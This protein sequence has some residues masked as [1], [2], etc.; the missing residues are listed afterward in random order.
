MADLTP[1][2][3]AQ[4]VSILRAAHQLLDAAPLV[5]EDAVSLQLI[6][7]ES[8]ARITHDSA[9]FQSP[10]VRALRAHVVLRSRFAEDR[11]AAAVNRGVT[12]CIILGAGFD[13]FA[14]RQP[15]WARAL[16]VIEVDQPASQTLKRER[17]AAAG[18]DTPPNVTFASIDFEQES[19]RDGL[20][21][22][23][24]SIA[25]PTFL[26]WL[27]VTVYLTES[28]V[29]A[30]LQTVVEFPAG[31][32]IVFTFTQPRAS[33]PSG[34]SGAANGQTLAE[35]A[36]SVGEPW[37][38][39]FTPDALEQKLRSFGFANVDFLEAAK[40]REIYFADRSDELQPPMRTSIVSALV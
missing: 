4:S 24:V 14:F 6:G 34:S 38:T 27:G 25:E 16:R 21:R 2:R 10:A 20:H 36:A 3:T 9:P 23:H 30:V 39:Y 33:D 22:H 15:E 37:Q 1:S 13:T 28:A 11:L 29:D 35:A 7:P 40:A 26:S 17:L 12:Q 5:L 19:L 18:V 31:S 32:E 8:A